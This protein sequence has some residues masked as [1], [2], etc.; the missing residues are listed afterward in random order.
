MLGT[1]RAAP[2]VP[3]ASDTVR[4]RDVRKTAASRHA[5]LRSFE[6]SWL[7]MTLDII[8]HFQRKALPVGAYLRLS[9]E[10]ASEITL[11]SLRALQL[12]S[13]CGTLFRRRRRR[14]L[15]R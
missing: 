2:V 8:Q 3:L 9:L 10:L 6:Q 7:P 4:E 15:E 1:H 5:D 12:R 14:G 13:K 11:P